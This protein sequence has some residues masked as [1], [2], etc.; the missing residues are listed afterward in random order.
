M[1]CSDCHKLEPDE[2]GGGGAGGS[3]NSGVG[4]ADDAGGGK[5]NDAGGS[6]KADDSGK[7]GKKNAPRTGTAD[8]HSFK[9]GVTLGP[10]DEVIINRLRNRMN[11]KGWQG[12]PIVV[13]FLPDGTKEILDGHHRVAAAKR[14]PKVSEVPWREATPEEVAYYLKH[15]HQF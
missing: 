11:K 10:E 13:R 14:S 5:A 4:K 8:P 9:P 2:G 1:A 6:C 3:C 15:R 12:E 7:A